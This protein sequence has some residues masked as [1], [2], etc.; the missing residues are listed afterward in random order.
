MPKTRYTDDFKEKIVKE[1][2]ETGNMSLVARNH[3]ISL[4]TVQ[5]WVGNYKKYGSVSK[6]S[7]KIHTGSNNVLSKNNDYLKLEKENDMLKKLLGEKELE[8]LILKDLVKKTNPH[9][10]KKLK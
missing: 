10:L 1:V 2:L 3:Q 5:Q 4:T 8:N 9:L 6:K 7:T